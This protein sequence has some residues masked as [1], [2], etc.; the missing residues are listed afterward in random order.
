MI[1][2]EDILPTMRIVAGTAAVVNLCD[3]VSQ[4]CLLKTKSVQEVY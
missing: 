4:F 1:A 2:T 3:E